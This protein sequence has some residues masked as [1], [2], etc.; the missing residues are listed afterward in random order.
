MTVSVAFLIFS[1][2]CELVKDKEVISC[3]ALIAMTHI[4]K[5][6]F[7]GY[8]FVSWKPLDGRKTF[9]S[10]FQ[11][12]LLGSGKYWSSANMICVAYG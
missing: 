8:T 2:P 11:G 7:N 1:W 6:F 10:V 4:L 9:K 12:K 5:V 3:V